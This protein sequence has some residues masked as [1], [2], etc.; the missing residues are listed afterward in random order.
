MAI[1]P[2]RRLKSGLNSGPVAVGIYLLVVGIITW[3]A[4]RGAQ[5]MGYNW[6]WYQIPK[7]I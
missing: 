6:Q 1:A 5:N 3:S 7:Y 4:Y 2:Q